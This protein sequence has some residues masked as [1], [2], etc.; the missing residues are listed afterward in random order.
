[1]SLASAER[2]R[3][4]AAND[5]SYE[6]RLEVER[7][8]AKQWRQKSKDRLRLKAR[9]YRARIRGLVFDALGNTCICCG[10]TRPEFLSIDHIHGGGRK[11]RAALGG[12]GTEFYMWL[13]RR[14][15]PKADFRILCMNC[16]FASRGGRAC[17]HTFAHVLALAV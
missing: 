12:G 8:S 3:L 5:G 9:D 11:H 7:R 13:W 6:R 1:M 10:E 4:K 14:G 17:P 2:Q 16:N 15:C